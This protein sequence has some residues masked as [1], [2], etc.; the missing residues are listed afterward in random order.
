VH[1]PDRLRFETLSNL[2]AILI[3]TVAANEIIGF[4]PREGLFYRGRSSKENLLRYTQIPLELEEL[5]TLLLGLPPARSQENWV[6]EEDSVSRQD[7]TGAKERVTFYPNTTIPTQWEHF[8]PDGERTL[9]VLFSDFGITFPGPFPLKISLEDHIHQ[10]YLEI[11][12]QEPELNVEL[13]YAVFV[14]KKPDYAR[15]VPLE[16]LGG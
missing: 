3:V 11:H 9:S 2:G 7:D 1:R 13:P 16:S 14:Q 4:H 15:E 6:E 10:R 5:T 8:D 12:Y